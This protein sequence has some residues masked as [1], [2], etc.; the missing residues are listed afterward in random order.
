MPVIR[1]PF[2]KSAVP[3]LPSASSPIVEQFAGETKL[4]DTSLDNRPASKSASAVSILK[5]DDERNSYKMSGVCN[6]CGP[7]EMADTCRELKLQVIPPFERHLLIC[8]QMCSG[9]R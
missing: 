7:L 3:S 4:E 5:N 2:R 6:S 8:G 1:N 9:E